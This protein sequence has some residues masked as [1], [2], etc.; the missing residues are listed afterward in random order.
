MFILGSLKARSG[1]PISDN[2][3]FFARCYSW[4]ATGENR[5][6]IGDFAPTRSVLPRVSG[7][8][9]R[10]PAIIFAWIVRPMNA[11]HLCHW[12]FLHKADFRQVKCN[13]R[14]K[15]AVLRFWAL[16]GGGWGTGQRTMIILGSLESAL[17]LFIS[18]NW[19]F[20]LGVTAEALERLSVQNR[21]FRSRGGQFTQNFK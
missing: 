18:G 15:M 1:L 13:F 9:G 7:R 17:W 21:Q 2:W 3:T 10:S 14:G 11:L 19:T 12:Q 6:K 5:S 8:R 4:G 20:S 16:W